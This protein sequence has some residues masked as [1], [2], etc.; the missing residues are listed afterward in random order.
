M[1][2]RSALELKRRRQIK[3]E[4]RRLIRELAQAQR[5][6]PQQVARLLGLRREQVRS[7]EIGAMIKI[8]RAASSFSS[9]PSKPAPPHSD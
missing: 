2:V 5:R 7:A 9:E 3:A 8:V 1:R 6:S 4:A